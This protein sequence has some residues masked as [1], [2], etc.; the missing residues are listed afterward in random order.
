V[1]GLPELNRGKDGAL[2]AML[3][4]QAER[5][6]VE[7]VVKATPTEGENSVD[8][9]VDAITTSL[10]ALTSRIQTIVRFLQATQ[11]GTI[12]ADY[13]LL[14]QVRKTRLGSGFHHMRYPCHPDV[15][16]PL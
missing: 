7:H 9:H 15:I 6:S 4:R 11:E 16:A 1:L 8:L 10:K 3:S 2:T 14:R 13:R 5:I 12:P